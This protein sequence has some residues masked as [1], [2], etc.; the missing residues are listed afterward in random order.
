MNLYVFPIDPGLL[1]IVAA[2][3]VV[4]VVI[5]ILAFRHRGTDR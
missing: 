3:V 2:A 1:L 5:T 4:F